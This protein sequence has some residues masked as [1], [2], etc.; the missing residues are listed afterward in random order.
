[1]WLMYPVDER[2]VRRARQGVLVLFAASVLWYS[3]LAAVAAFGSGPVLDKVVGKFVELPPKTP[4]LK[5]I[6][7]LIAAW[8][9]A[10]AMRL[11]GYR[12]MRNVAGAL[13]TP[14]GV[15]LALLGGVVAAGAVGT[16]KL[17]VTGMFAL[18]AV[19]GAAFEMRFLRVPA[20]L[21]GLVVSAGAVRAVHRYFWVRT[22]WLGV[23]VFPALLMLVAHIL[24]DVPAHEGGPYQHAIRSIN[25]LLYPI[26]RAFSLLIAV[27]LP[28]LVV[29]Y[30]ALLR[31][32]YL[33]LPR[34]LD[35]QGPTVQLPPPVKPGFDQLKQVLQ[36]QDW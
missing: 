11:V 29:A 25:G 18:V 3:A 31:Q 4:N 28:L 35:P 8:G 32:L 36:P 6:L 20:T 23:V 12:L 19:A 10:G 15:A 9:G 34:V 24:T 22:A 1:M 2:D 26:F 13:G 7:F 27:T 33:A 16:I 21:F 5:P 17:G 14:E 30:W